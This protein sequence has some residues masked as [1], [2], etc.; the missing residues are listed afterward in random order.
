MNDMDS[1]QEISLEGGEN[2]SLHFSNLVIKDD[3]TEHIKNVLFYKNE[4]KSEPEGDYIDNIHEKWWGKWEL[5]ERH[6][7]YIQCKIF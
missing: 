4:I 2:P 5:L 1:V 3:D 6:H 7:G